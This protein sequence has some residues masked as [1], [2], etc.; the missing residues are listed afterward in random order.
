MSARPGRRLLLHEY[1]AKYL[2]SHGRSL[3]KKTP[4]KAV[5]FFQDIKTCGAPGPAQHIQT[6]R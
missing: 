4:A 6:A 5:P 1:C 3:P 2:P